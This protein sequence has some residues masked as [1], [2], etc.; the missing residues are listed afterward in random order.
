[1]LSVVNADCSYDECHYAECHFFIL[2]LS[3]AA[4]HL[5]ITDW[6]IHYLVC[7]V[8]HAKPCSL[9]AKTTLSIK[10]LFVT[11][12]INDSQHNNALYRE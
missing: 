10:G 12:S 3:V 8:E 9:G 5:L 2:M 7:M 4:S 11:L 6:Y 1:M